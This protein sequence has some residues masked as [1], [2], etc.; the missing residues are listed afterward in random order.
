M[1]TDQVRLYRWFKEFR[2]YVEA[3]ISANKPVNIST[4]DLFMLE[5]VEHVLDSLTAK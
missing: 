3:R 2:V 4:L 1:E 5:R